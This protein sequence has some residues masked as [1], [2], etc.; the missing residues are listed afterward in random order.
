[1]TVHNFI[2]FIFFAVGLLA[3]C[4][5]LLNAKWLL[6]SKSVGML[7]RL[8]GKGGARLF[9]LVFGALLMAMGCYFHFSIS[10]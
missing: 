2:H 7:L 8:L 5:S 6:Q 3:F 10:Q 4:A 9:Y 1:M